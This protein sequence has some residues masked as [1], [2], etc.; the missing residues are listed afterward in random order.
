MKKDNFEQIF[1]DKLGTYE[2]PYNAEA[3]NNLKHKINS[4][5]NGFPFKKVFLITGIVLISTTSI[6]VS[7]H[8]T[9][10][11]ILTDKENSI[12][13]QKNTAYDE[14]ESAQT[15]GLDN[16]SIISQHQTEKTENISNNPITHDNQ[17]SQIDHSDLISSKN[18]KTAEISN[19]IAN[20]EVQFVN[21]ETKPNYTLGKISR[22]IICLG[23]SI[24]ISNSS[25]KKEKVLARILGE[26]IT[27]EPNKS[28][29]INVTESTKIE[30]L[31]VNGEVIG[32][33][34]IVLLESSEPSFEMDANLYEDGLPVAHFNT[35]GNFSNYSWDFGNGLFST[36]KNPITNYFKKGSYNVKLT[37]A[38]DNGCV[39]T[40][41]QQL[42]ILND[43]NLLATNSIRLNDPDYQT[44][45]FMPYCLRERGVPFVLTIMDPKD[46]SVVF[47]SSD[48][49]TPWDGKDQR[50]GSMLPTQKTYVWQV[51]IENTVPGEIG[52][53]QGT[54]IIVE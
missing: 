9:D 53:Y 37:I 17:N 22:N 13:N 47:T 8:M 18:Q 38:D 11:T 48:I 10:E 30:Y 16:H 49:G 54:V 28:V 12:S 2:A 15:Q 31:G 40:T 14:I 25:N 29:Q 27:I 26:I 34:E 23:E 7:Y 24:F 41:S 3:W 33:D 32:F 39:S 21:S 20:E 4:K 6:L 44:R 42:T 51:Q 5:T 45:T 35:I 19:E 46:N 43:Y 50:N 36:Q 1:S 52:I